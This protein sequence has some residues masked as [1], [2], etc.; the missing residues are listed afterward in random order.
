MRNVILGSITLPWPISDDNID[1]ILNWMFDSSESILNYK[2]IFEFYFGSEEDVN[3]SIKYMNKSKLFIPYKDNEYYGPN[4]M[5][6]RIVFDKETE[7]FLNEL[8]DEH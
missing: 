7:E 8:K 1:F 6:L 3:K 4:G 5:I 2:R